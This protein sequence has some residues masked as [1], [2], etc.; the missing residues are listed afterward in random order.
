MITP[1]VVI[2]GGLKGRKIK[3]RNPETHG[4]RSDEISL[5]IRVFTHEV[6]ETNR[7]WGTFFNQFRLQERYNH[8]TDV[9]IDG[10]MKG[11]QKETE[12]E[13]VSRA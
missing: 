4:I 5:R 8:P 12:Y 2:D 6:I 10:G 3:E 7:L 1:G 11:N 13:R 9:V